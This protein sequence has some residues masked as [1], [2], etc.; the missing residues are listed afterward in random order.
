MAPEKW[1]F[2]NWLSP[3]DV[4]MLT[5]AV[6]DLHRAYPGRFLTDVRTS[7][8]ALW[9]HNP[10][11]TKLKPDAP[12]VRSLTCHYPLIQRCNSAPYHFIHGFIEYLNDH[13]ETQIKPTEFKG[14]IHLS[15]KEQSLPGPVEEKFGLTGPYWLIAAGGK[16]D[17]TIKWWHRRRWQEVVDRLAGRV[18]FVQVGERG[19]YHPPLRGVLDFR[20]RTDLRKLVRLVYFATGLICPVTFYMHLAA[21][22]PLAPSQRRLRPCI[23]IA[24]GRE[25]AHWEQYPGHQFLHTIGQLD[26]C[27][28]GG[29]W[30]SRTVPLGDGSPLDQPEA[31]CHDVTRAG[32]PRCMDLITAEQVCQLVDNSNIIEHLY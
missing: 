18:Q 6:R 3:G 10:Y 1:I 13:L 24:G 32:L 14:D 4:V 26:C 2:E 11:L 23:V 8:P 20:G 16:Y 5:A 31:L 30:K 7:C 19:H 15:R 25:P 22:V 21:A 17:F 27:A 12:G 28:Q 9:K 29:C